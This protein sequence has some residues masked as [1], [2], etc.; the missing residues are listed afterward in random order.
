MVPSEADGQALAS[1]QSAILFYQTRISYL[2]IAVL[3]VSYVLLCMFR[4]QRTKSTC[5]TQAVVS[6]TL[7]IGHAYCFFST[8]NII[9]LQKRF[10]LM[11]L[12]YFQALWSFANVYIV[13]C[14][15]TFDAK[16]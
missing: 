5:V 8:F 13:S 16:C 3:A 2:L 4:G 15:V 12:V 14:N 11:Y 10:T 6:A 7:S 1:I 9:L